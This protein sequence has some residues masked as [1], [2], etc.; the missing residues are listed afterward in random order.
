MNRCAIRLVWDILLTFWSPFC[1][2][3]LHGHMRIE[4]V[5]G[6]ISFLASI[7]TA[8]VH[9]LNLFVSSPRPLVLLSAGNWN[10][11]VYLKGTSGQNT[12]QKG[13]QRKNRQEG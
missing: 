10:E 7:P 8:L 11:R 5:Q 9:A 1:P 2:V 3:S 12:E 13:V 4:M 6:A